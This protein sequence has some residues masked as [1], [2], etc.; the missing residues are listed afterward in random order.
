MLE[1][2]GVGDVPAVEAEAGLGGVDAV[3]SDD[4]GEAGVGGGELAVAA[5]VLAEVEVV[6]AAEVVLGAGAAD[7]GELAV[8]VEEEFDL[9]LAPPAAVVDAPGHVGADVLALSPDAVEDG[10]DILVGER[11]HPPELGV[12]VGGVIGDV[13]EGVVD[14][15]VE[16]HLLQPDVLHG[17]FAALPK[18]HLP[19]GVEGAAGVDADGE[20]GDLGVLA[21]AAGEEVADGALD[22]GLVLAVPVDAEDA[23]APVAGGGHPYVLNRPRVIDLRD[24]RRL[25]GLD[26]NIG[27]DLPS[28]AEVA[29]GPL[30]GALDGHA[31]LALFA[32][33]VLGGDGASLCQ[34]EAR[35]VS[36]VHSESVEGRHPALLHVSSRCIRLHRR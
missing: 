28:L 32:G 30:G 10:V 35:E 23:V 6:G 29:G 16:R 15:V 18:R 7:G 1:A 4:L 33:E 2:D 36:E 34:G 27:G 31:A 22:G 25:A 8:A 5:L 17:D 24:H 13:G 9:A 20:G 26:P 11:V 21:P 19:V 3:G 12:E 14:L